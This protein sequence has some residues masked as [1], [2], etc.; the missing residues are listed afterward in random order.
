MTRR[1]YVIDIDGTM[2]PQN[3]SARSPNG[4]ANR[5]SCFPASWTSSPRSSRP[6]IASSIDRPP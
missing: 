6:A 1:T 5:T 2:L 3:T 4:E